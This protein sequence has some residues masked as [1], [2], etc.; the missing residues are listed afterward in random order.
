MAARGDTRSRSRSGGAGLL[1]SLVGAGALLVVGFVLGLAV[2]ASWEDPDLLVQ[3]MAGRGEEV[4]LHDEAVVLA[5][6]PPLGAPAAEEVPVLAPKTVAPPP[7]SAPAPV[8][9]APP[10][11][12]SAPVAAPPRA[13]GFSVQVGAFREQGQ[14]RDLERRVEGAGFPAFVVSAAGGGAQRWRV[15]VGPV[16]S[17]AEADALAGRL[18]REQGLPTWV[19]SDG[20]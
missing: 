17:R 18:K 9:A 6:P 2:G 5:A 19:V 1:V 4:P 12:A 8:A 14:A 15:R 16:A 7:P 13:G 3:A 11:S 10:P 20:G